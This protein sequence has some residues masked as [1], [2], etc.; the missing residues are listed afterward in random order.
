MKIV[1][2]RKFKLRLQIITNYIK[3]D[4]QSA[5]VKFA[6]DLKKIIKD[7]NNS[8]LKYRPSI[9]FD[10]KNI[11]DMI[12]KGYTIIYKVNIQEETIVISDIFNQNKR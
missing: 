5:S 7:L 10:D 4:K 6:K 2:S 8:P 3:K 9:Y 12:F 11:R 1:E